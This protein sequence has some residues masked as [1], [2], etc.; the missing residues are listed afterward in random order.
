MDKHLQQQYLQ[1]MGIQAWSLRDQE[2]PVVESTRLTEDVF[3]EAIEKDVTTLDWGS[4]ESQVSQ[5]SLCELQQSRTQTVFGIGSQSADWLIIGEA[6]GKEEDL[7]GEPF[8]GRAGQL[9]NAM[10]LAI[11][12]RREQVYIAN[13]L[14]CRPPNNRDPRPDEVVQCEP[15][16]MQQIALLQPKIILAIGR[17]AAQNL[18]KTDIPIGKLRGQVHNLGDTGIPVIATYHPA[19]LLRSPQEKS[20]AWQDLQLAMQTIKGNQK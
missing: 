11:G 18:L 5:C 3:Q 4:L 16:L 1:A 20:K 8:V 10:L 15:Y 2:S 7:Q 17:I 12:L 9:L 13:I 14:K 6:P 19:Y